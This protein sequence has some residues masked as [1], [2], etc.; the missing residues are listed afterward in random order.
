MTKP[1]P[2]KRQKRKNEGAEKNARKGVAILQGERV[3]NANSEETKENDRE[4]HVGHH[5]PQDIEADFLMQAGRRPNG[6][7]PHKEAV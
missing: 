2:K 1:V 3:G 6:A 5:G 7:P 4:K